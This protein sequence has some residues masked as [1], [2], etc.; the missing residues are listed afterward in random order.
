MCFDIYKQFAAKG[1][2]VFRYFLIFLE[3]YPL[4]LR[5]SF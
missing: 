5:R 3:R 2:T 1:L 4:K